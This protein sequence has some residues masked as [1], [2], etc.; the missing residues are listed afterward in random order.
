MALTEGWRRDFGTTIGWS[1]VWTRG[2]GCAELAALLAAGEPKP[3]DA[4]LRSASIRARADLLVAKRLT[5]FDLIGTV[6]PVGFDEDTVSE[7]VAAVSGGPHSVLAARVAARLSSVL[8]VDG[9]L[10]S[11]SP[12][13]GNDDAAERT[14]SGLALAVPELPG[15]IVRV[16]S[17]K[18][19]VGEMSPTALLVVGASG[20]S[21]LQRQF[22]GPGK[23]LRV[24][25]PGGAVVVRSA[26]DRCF[27]RMSDPDGLAARMLVGVARDVMDTAAFPVVEDG[28][29]VG[30]VRRSTLA[31]ADPSSTVGEHMEE[32][33]FVSEDD[34]VDVVS[35]V[36]EHLDHGPVPVV[37]SDGRLVG[38]I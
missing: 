29:L 28:L 38:L 4:D 2:E 22:M 26:P 27:Q 34:P 33:V 24:G 15:R 36:M 20:G 23:Q 21:W 16:D 6:V 1:V 25:A 18:A 5:S 35:E 8:G 7:V 31:D 3:A 13:D 9:C 19:L 17:A 12:A 37:D 11:A 14:L 30:I 32:P 10:V